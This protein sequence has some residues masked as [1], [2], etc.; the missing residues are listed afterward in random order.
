MEML[1]SL[2]WWVLLIASVVPYSIKRRRTQHMQSLMLSALAWCFELQ[3]RRGSCSWSFSL[4]WVEQLQHSQQ[5]RKAF[6]SVWIKSVLT[7]TKKAI[8]LRR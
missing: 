5:L 2:P 4:P 7:L 3:W 6:R 8:S 1:L